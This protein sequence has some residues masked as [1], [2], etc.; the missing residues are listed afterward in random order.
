MIGRRKAPPQVTAAD[1]VTELKGFDAFEVRLGDVMRGER[2]T[3][4]KSLL[5]VQRELKIKASFVAAIENADPSAFETPGFV[6]GYVRSYAR[7][8]EM[9]PDWAY[10]QFCKESGFSVAESF[11]PTG[12]LGKQKTKKTDPTLRGTVSSDPFENPNTPFAPRG[13]GVFAGVQPGALGSLCVLVA[14]IGGLGYG[15]W[16]VLE[17]VQKVQLT[18]V[19]QTP[20]VVTEVAGLAPETTTT[21]ETAGLTPPT[22]EAFDRLYRPQPLEVP[23]LTARDGPIATLDPS[24]VGTLPGATQPEVPQLQIAE[25]VPTVAPAPEPAAPVVVA[26]GDPPVVMFAV[27]PSWVRVRAAD[28]TVIFEQILD[29]GEQ[30][31][32]PQTEE[33][34]TLRAGNAGSVYF[35]IADQTYGPA[36]DGGAV[37]KNVALAP[38]A[39]RDIYTVADMNADRDLAKTVASLTVPPSQ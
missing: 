2:A 1:N 28:G 33:P 6:A 37:V 27:R 7:Y 23:V 4:G 38:D 20:G 11:M 34:P 32:L 14:L 10:D 18:A 22:V 5:D 36:G 24:S 17:Q 39:L 8:L 9:D 13:E 31:V 15:G 26:E 3:K 16:A 25:A 30:Y 12:S 29:A 19:D 35:Q 21:V